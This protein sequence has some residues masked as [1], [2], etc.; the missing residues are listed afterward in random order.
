MPEELIASAFDRQP[1]STRREV[2]RIGAVLAATPLSV[3]LPGCGE[4]QTAQQS[5]A[6]RPVTGEIP[7]LSRRHLGSLEVS[8]LGFGCM[9]IVWAYGPPI[10]RYEAVRLVR[11]AYDRGITFFDTAEIYGPFTS[12]EIVGE[13]LA[14]VR[15]KVVIASK[16]GFDVTPE[17]QFRGLN[18]RPEHIRRVTDESLRRLRSERIDLFYQ[19]RVDPE[20]PI[21]DVAGTIKDLITAGKI[22]HFGLSEAGAATIRR[23]HAVQPVAAV[24]NEYSLWSRDSDLEVLPICEELGIGLVPWS[25]LG[26]GYLTGKVTPGRT[27][28]AGDLRGGFPRFTPEARRANW[29]VVELLQKIGQRHEATPGQVALAWLLALKPWIVPIPGTTNRD[30][31]A[32][33]LGALS[34]SLSS[35]DMREI[36]DGFAQIRVQGA[37]STERLLA[38]SDVGA[39]PGSSSADGH[40]MTPLP[41]P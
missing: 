4:A 41:R 23:A 8:A 24:Q 20:V 37:R 32:E 16:F 34:L 17:G 12:E 3:A 28:A 30:H 36:A 5:L 21:E 15:D 35:Q 29:P 39:R 7:K 19:H 25:P 26:M 33:N 13:A 18:S 27:F 31:Q 11:Q 14:S 22:G 10:D 2:M 9:N 1:L 38:Q 6:E 40:G